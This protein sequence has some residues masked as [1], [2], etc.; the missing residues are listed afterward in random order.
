VADGNHTG[1]ELNIC[2]KKVQDGWADSNADKAKGGGGAT[3]RERV[4]QLE[5][6]LVRRTRK[7]IQRIVVLGYQKDFTPGGSER[8]ENDTRKQKKQTCEGVGEKKK[9]QLSE[10]KSCLTWGGCVRK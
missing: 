2:P 3:P 7:K 1:H 8:V 10:S 9:K 4:S 6:F 5:T